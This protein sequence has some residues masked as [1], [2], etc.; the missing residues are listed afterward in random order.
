M[1]NTFQN[2]YVYA[3]ISNQFN[4]HQTL[5]A[6]LWRENL[7]KIYKLEKQSTKGGGIFETIVL[8]KE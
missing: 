8:L 1:I 2:M 7:M 4:E 3:C 5:F 6:A